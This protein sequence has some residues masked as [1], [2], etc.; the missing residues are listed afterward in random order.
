MLTVHLAGLIYF[1]GCQH[2][3]KRA[4]VPD[5]TKGE[6]GLPPHHASI[7][8][9]A[10]RYDSDQWW[11]DSKFAHVLEV[12][13]RDGTLNK[14]FVL[15]FRIPTP[16]QVAFPDE[17]NPLDFA[18]ENGLP[19]LKKLSDEFELDPENPEAIARIPLRG[20]KLETRS[21]GEVGVVQW[22]IKDTPD[23]I[24]IQA[25]PDRGAARTLTLRNVNELK[26]TAALG[27]LGPEVVF[28]NAPDLIFWPSGRHADCCHRH[29]DGTM[30]DGHAEHVHAAAG[31]SSGTRHGSG[32]G[33]AHNHSNH[34]ALYG[35][36]DAK[37]NGDQLVGK[38]LTAMLQEVAE[39]RAGLDFNHGL[40]RYLLSGNELPNGECTGSC[41]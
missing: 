1:D 12:T 4:L 11:P 40:L 5:G 21:F 7:W 36:L 27:V 6:D 30:A 17:G 35:K 39:N 34:F 10:D 38:E 2:P 24:T 23:V 14:V 15:E 8:V 20:G 26:K 31:D 25:K 28:S 32:N 37:R 19:S 22:T 16:S 29:D 9:E 13:E 18:I 33:A 3:E 41:C